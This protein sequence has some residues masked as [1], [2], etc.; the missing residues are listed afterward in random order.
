MSAAADSVVTIEREAAVAFVRLAAPPLNLLTQALRRALTDAVAAAEA[1][2][3]VRALVVAGAEN[4]CAG[5]DLKEFGARVD[6]AV[7]DAHGR[8]GHAMTLRL[9]GC[10]KPIVAAIEGACLGG[11][12]EIALACDLRIAA[13]DARL[14]LPEIGRGVFPGTGGL[15]LLERL[16]GPARTKRIALGGEVFAAA[17]PEADGIVDLRVEPGQALARALEVARAFSARPAGSVGAIKR[18]VD[19]D[20][21]TRLAERLEVERAEYVAAFRRADAREGWRAFLEKRP[22]AWAHH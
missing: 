21:R 7:A 3:S 22:P 10:D 1:D 14:G 16:V 13:H 11:G 19:G 12:F 2:P 9:V 6:P 17:S 18:L 5:A 4:F 15:P 8:N 20:F